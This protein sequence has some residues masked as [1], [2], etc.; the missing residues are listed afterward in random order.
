ME[1][2]VE[3]IVDRVMENIENKAPK[4]KKIEGP[5]DKKLNCK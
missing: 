1:D 3:E 5:V 2:D 4:H